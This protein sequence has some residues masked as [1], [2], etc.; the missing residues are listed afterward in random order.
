VRGNE[1]AATEPWH[2]NIPPS[3]IHNRT[4]WVDRRWSTGLNK[5]VGP[6]QPGPERN[7]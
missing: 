3:N 5:E 2:V 1:A 6:C 7:T 4:E